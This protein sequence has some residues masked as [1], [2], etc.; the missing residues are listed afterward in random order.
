MYIAIPIIVVTDLTNKHNSLQSATVPICWL[1]A[2][3]GTVCRTLSCQLRLSQFSSINSKPT[4]SLGRS[5]I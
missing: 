5:R 4:C 2:V 1:E 3:S